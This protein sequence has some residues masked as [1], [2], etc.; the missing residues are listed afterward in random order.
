M[1]QLAVINGGDYTPLI[2]ETLALQD[3]EITEW[4][5][6]PSWGVMI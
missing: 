2:T 4:E 5:T 3:Y 1:K 6:I